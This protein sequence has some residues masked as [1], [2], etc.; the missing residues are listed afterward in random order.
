[1][2]TTSHQAFVTIV[3]PVYNGEAYLRECIE[4]VLA[5]TWQNWEYIILNNASTDGSLAVANEYAA[6]DARIRV[7]SNPHT[8]P[9]VQNHNAALRLMSAQAQYCKP[10][11]ADDWLR[12]QCVERLV[13]A[14]ERDPAI[15]LVCTWAFDGRH[16]FGDSWPYPAAH[17]AGRDVA[18]AHLLDYRRMYALG[19]PTV[20]LIRA[21]LIREARAFYPEDNPLASD[22]QACL[23]ILAQADFSFVHEVLAFTRVHEATVTSVNARLQGGV[24]GR[25]HTLL[26]CGP[27][28]LSAEEFGGLRARLLE[29][30]YRVLAYQAVRRPGSDFWAFQQRHLDLMGCPFDKWRLRRAVCRYLANLALNPGELAHNALR[31]LQRRRGPSAQ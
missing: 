16:V 15:G 19:S 20:S 1:M 29:D 13:G 7:H 23:Q 12:P 2:S 8:L 17:V 25:M 26:K 14:A 4:S 6:R 18:R 5:Q 28:F 21:D 10:L 30:H 3:T 9:M 31:R 24:L 27:A 11:M 22:F